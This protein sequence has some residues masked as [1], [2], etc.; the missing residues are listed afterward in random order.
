MCK[1]TLP[2]DAE[3]FYRDRGRANFDFP[4]FQGS[5]KECSKEKTKKWAEAHP[6][7]A[8]KKGKEKYDPS[9][10]GA[11]YQKYR[12]D[13]LKRRSNDRVSVQ[14]RLKELFGSARTRAKRA[15]LPFTIT[16]EWVLDA[17]EKQDGK[18]LLTGI[19]LAFERN[20]YGLRFHR[21][22]S[23]SLDQ[24]KPGEGYT[25]ENTRLVCVVVNLALNRFGED[26]FKTVCEGF[27]ANHLH[28]N[29]KSPLVEPG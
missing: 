24:I 19:P 8:K 12:E 22:F 2:L 15:G 4:G 27:L 25:L 5:C 21:P 29:L 17:F 14:G 28:R 7:Y 6:E 11:R 26:V 1:R 18:C 23:P 3:H 10:N 20:P 13:Y 16:I 9:K